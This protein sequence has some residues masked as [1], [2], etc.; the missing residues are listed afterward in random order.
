M[1]SQA[2]VRLRSSSVHPSRWQNR[3]LS[4]LACHRTEIDVHRANPYDGRYAETTSENRESYVP[5][6]LRKPSIQFLVLVVGIIV[7][8]GF[9]FGLST[10]GLASSES[11]QT[12]ALDVDGVRYSF[13]PSTCSVSES[14]FIA[15]GTGTV[16]GEPFWV[17]ASG[18]RLNLALGEDD[19]AERPEDDKL[20]LVSVEDVRWR[21]T[22]G[23]IT[24][25]A[26]M[27]DERDTNSEI[28]VGTLSVECPVA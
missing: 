9:A 19:E 27:R 10:A 26:I 2:A 1:A 6:Q 24:A 8:T 28:V 25:S 16:D 13:A 4:S 21:N 15:A 22:D 17:S 3:G 18:D 12:A 11:E 14:D 5:T 23:S 7:L 20:W